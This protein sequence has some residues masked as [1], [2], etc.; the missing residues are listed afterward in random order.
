MPKTEMAQL[1]TENKLHLLYMEQDMLIENIQQRK[2]SWYIS[3]STVL[4][5]NLYY[6]TAHGNNGEGSNSR[7]CSIIS[8]S[9]NLRI[10]GIAM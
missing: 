10:K 7:Q 3:K 6:Y 1:M 5:Q 4:Q 8:L 2:W 9:R